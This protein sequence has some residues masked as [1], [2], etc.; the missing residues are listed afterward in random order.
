MSIKLDSLSRRSSILEV[1]FDERLD[2]P[3][4]QDQPRRTDGAKKTVPLGRICHVTHRW[5][6]VADVATG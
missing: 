1:R 3:P 5:R 4:T 2:V 6:G